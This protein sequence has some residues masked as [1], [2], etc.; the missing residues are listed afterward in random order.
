MPAEFDHGGQQFTSHQDRAQSPYQ[1]PSVG[2]RE[3]GRP[4]STAREPRGEPWARR[5]EPQFECHGHWGEEPHPRGSRAL[6]PNVAGELPDFDVDARV[7]RW[8]ALAARTAPVS[9]PADARWFRKQSAVRTAVS[10]R[11]ASTRA[12]PAICSYD[13]ARWAA[14]HGAPGN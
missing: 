3:R 1:S 8:Y 9:A 7:R 10:R 12:T 14:L 4:G 6:R 5:K 11:P 13:C 2:L